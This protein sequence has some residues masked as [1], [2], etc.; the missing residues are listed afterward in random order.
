MKEQLEAKLLEEKS[1]LSELILE[2]K[3]I[4]NVI[5]THEAELRRLQ[6]STEDLKKP[7]FMDSVSTI[8]KQL[9]EAVARKQSFG[10]KLAHQRSAVESIEDEIKARWIDYF[11]QE[12][13]PAKRVLSDAF[14]AFVKASVD[15]QTIFGK[16]SIPTHRIWEEGLVF[17]VHNPRDPSEREMERRSARSMLSIAIEINRHRALLGHTAGVPMAE[18]GSAEIA[19]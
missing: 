14:E 19:A 11:N 2:S 7:N 3:N 13:S 1:Q 18:I 8:E 10:C 12:L 4:E 6:T 16:Y 9:G 17:D 5:Q 15:V